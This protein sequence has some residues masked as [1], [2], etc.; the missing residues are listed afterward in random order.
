[1]SAQPITPRPILRLPRASSPICSSGYSLTS[2]TLSRK[3]TARWT[4]SPRA[5]PI[6]IRLTVADRH[7]AGEIDRAEV[8][9]L[10]RKQRLLAARV[11]RLD[12]AERRGRVVPVHP[13]DE[14]DARVTGRPRHLDDELVDLARIELT[15]DLPRPRVHEVVRAC[16]PRPRP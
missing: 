11:R 3:R 12:L 14:D 5:I 13:V 2:M 6:D 8:A 7:E 9:R 4:T 15:V 1:M 16:P 10:V